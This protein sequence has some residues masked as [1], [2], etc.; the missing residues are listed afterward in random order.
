VTLAHR[1][2]ERLGRKDI[3]PGGEAGMPDFTD[4]DRGF[5]GW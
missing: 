1:V 2:P 4:A 3:C 5:I